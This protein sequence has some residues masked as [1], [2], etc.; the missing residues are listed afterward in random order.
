MPMTVIVTRDVPDRFRGFLA[1]VALE[2]AAGVYT[3][4]EMTASVR[5]R[6]WTVLESWHRHASQGAVVMTWPDGA[7]PG[8][9][10]VLVLGD[11]PR[12]LWVADGL[13]LA[14]RDVP[15]EPGAPSLVP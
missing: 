2:I 3:A 14:R 7:A 15:A 1:S 13:V 10:R 9:Q 5:E 8:G 4:P 6:T 12:D 11:A